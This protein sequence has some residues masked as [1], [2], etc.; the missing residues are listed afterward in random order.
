MK[1]ELDARPVYL[2]KENTI[3]G[4]FLICYLATVIIRILQIHELEDND[5]YQEL[6]KFIRDFKFTKYENKYINMATKTDFLLK[7]MEKTDLPLDCAIL[8][9]NQ[10]KKIMNYEL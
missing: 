2:Q 10:Y 9:A 1:S 3:K 7:V 8:S 4:H 5:S 6:F